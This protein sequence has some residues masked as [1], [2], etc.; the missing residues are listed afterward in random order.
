MQIIYILNLIEAKYD[1]KQIIF[2]IFNMQI[3][4]ILNLIEAKY[5]IKQIIFVIFR[6]KTKVLNCYIYSFTE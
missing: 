6:C 2:V 3:I 4:Y 1:I 5:D